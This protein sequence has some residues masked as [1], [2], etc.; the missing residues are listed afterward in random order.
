[1]EAKQLS[2]AI[3]ELEVTAL[4]SPQFSGM[5]R[6]HSRAKANLFESLIIQ[7]EDLYSRY[8]AKQAEVYAHL[9]AIE[10]LME[11]ISSRERM[12]LRLYYIEGLTW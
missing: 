3:R 8:I 6:S 2:N 12:I 4:R 10:S 11:A 7:R 5:P 9:L 1:M